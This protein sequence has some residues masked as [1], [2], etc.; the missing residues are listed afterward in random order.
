MNTLTPQALDTLVMR[1]GALESGATY[2]FRLTV[3]N[4]YGAFDSATIN[5]TA[6]RNPYGGYIEI[7]PTNGTAMTSIFQLSTGNW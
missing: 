4:S 6:G 7:F 3:S 2:A 1:A 5:I